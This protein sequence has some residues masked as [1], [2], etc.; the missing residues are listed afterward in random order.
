MIVSCCSCTVVKYQEQAREQ[1]RGYSVYSWEYKGY[2]LSNGTL[3][4]DKE[5]AL[6]DS[7]DP[8]SER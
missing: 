1:G 8:F 7:Q 3:T 4:K 5:L 2:I 6:I